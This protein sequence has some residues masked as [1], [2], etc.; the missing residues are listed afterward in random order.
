RVGKSYVLDVSYTSQS[1]DLARDIAAAIADVYLV[2][3]L[4]SKY[5]ATLR[6]GEWLQE[7]IEELRQQAL[8]TDLSVQKFRSEHGLVEAVS[9]TLISDQQLSEI[10]WV[11]IS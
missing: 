7:R 4:N 2:D 3:K 5:E 1:P 10:N 6:A 11:L 8:D 9:G